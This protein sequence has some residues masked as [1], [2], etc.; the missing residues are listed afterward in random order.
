MRRTCLTVLFGSL[1]CL[2]SCL[3]QQSRPQITFGMTID[4]LHKQFGMPKSYFDFFTK[5][6]LATEAEAQI[7]RQVSKGYRVDAVYEF[8]TGLNT[9]ELRMATCL[10]S[11]RSRLRPTERFVSFQFELDKP[12]EDVKA[13]LADIPEAVSLCSQEC[14]I[15]SNNIKS[16]PMLF[17][18]HTNPSP[19]ELKEAGS[20]AVCWSDKQ[21]ERAWVKGFQ[22]EFGEGGR[23]IVSGYYEVQVKGRYYV[24]PLSRIGTWRS[25]LKQE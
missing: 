1:Q 3:G 7:A 2:S 23:R 16:L 22:F 19:E 25:S 6:Y 13:L 9:Y 10:D 5:R 20:V 12:V 24:Q 15:F 18:Q 4:E 14:T 8:K 21:S 17:V 11:S